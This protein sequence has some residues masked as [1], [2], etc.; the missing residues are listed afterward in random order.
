M[1]IDPIRVTVEGILI[2]RHYLGDAR[3]FEIEIK[4]GFVLVRPKAAQPVPLRPSESSRF[5]FV[6]IATSQNPNAS[7]EAEAILAKE[8][9]QHT[10]HHSCSHS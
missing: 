7:L 3:E 1:D 6:G 9:G 5:S 4:N 8:L 2:P 10:E